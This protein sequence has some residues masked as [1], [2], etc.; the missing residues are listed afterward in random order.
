[1]ASSYPKPSWYLVVKVT[2]L[3]KGITVTELAKE[4][5]ASRVH[6]SYVING[7]TQSEVLKNKIFEFLGISA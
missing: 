4:I 2:M 7:R 5:G 6:T 1:M 3:N